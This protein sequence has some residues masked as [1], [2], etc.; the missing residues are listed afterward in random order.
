M[1]T[2]KTTQPYFE[3]ALVAALMT[4]L[5]LLPI[6]GMPAVASA[7]RATVHKNM[8][9]PFASAARTASANSSAFDAGDA[10]VLVCY[11]SVT[12]NSGTTPT[13]DVKFQDSP[14]GGTT[15]FDV[16]GG[17][18]AQVTTTNGTQV[19]STTRK[20]ASRVRCVA[21][22]AGTTPSYTFAVWFMSYRSFA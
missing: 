8:Q 5:V 7:Q 16:A 14:D 20:F 21:T 2:W 19:V 17:S 6:V 22:I 11:L 15:W 12:A 3:A 4:V 18:F 1:K 10:D 9:V 13:L